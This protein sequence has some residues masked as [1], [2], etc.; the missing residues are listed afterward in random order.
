MC[1]GGG[2]LAGLSGGSRG[3]GDADHTCH[4]RDDV[5]VFFFSFP[6]VNKSQQSL[7]AR[8]PTPTPPPP[9]RVMKPSLIFTVILSV[10]ALMGL[11]FFLSLPHGANCLSFPHKVTKIQR[12]LFKS[13]PGYL[14]PEPLQETRDPESSCPPQPGNKQM[15]AAAD[16]PTLN[17]IRA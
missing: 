17:S 14:E 15:A 1:G 2:A 16:T 6:K 4:W 11:F 9:T 8:V 10:V 5:T 12:L 7:G 3:S 13:H